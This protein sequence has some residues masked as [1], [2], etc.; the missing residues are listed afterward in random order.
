MKLF[1]R[2]GS[3]LI[4]TS[5]SRKQSVIKEISHRNLV[6]LREKH[7]DFLKLVDSHGTG[8]VT[9]TYDYEKKIA[10][11]SLS[12][13]ELHN[14]ISGRMMNELATVLDN[15]LDNGGKKEVL[16]EARRKIREERQKAL[17]PA[18][19]VMGLIVRSSGK[20]F[21][22]GADLNLVRGIGELVLCSLHK[23]ISVILHKAIL[24]FV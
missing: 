2:G 10:V 3:I 24:L 9:L 14:S 11:L 17:E 20:T 21:S 15:L 7:Q 18:P 19:Y 16:I 6:S 12:N 13:E 4:S 23:L 5:S 1:S 8:S 22:A